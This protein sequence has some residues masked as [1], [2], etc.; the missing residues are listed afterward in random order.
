LRQ[1]LCVAERKFDGLFPE[2]PIL[3]MIHLPALPAAPRNTMTLDELVAFALEELE[4]LEGAGIDGVIV[5]NVGDTPFFREGVP[6][7]TVAAMG[8]IVRE[9]ARAATVPV[10]VN[11]LRNAWEEAVSVA[12]VA[13]AQ[14][15]R[16]NVVIGAYVT[17][18]GIIQGEA[19][20]M[21]RLRKSLDRDV[22][23]LGDVHVKHAAPL[24]DVPLVDA[25]RDLAERGGVD[26]VIV[27][28]RRSPDPPTAEMVA[29]VVDAIELP[30]LI[31]SGLGKA[32]ACEFYELSGGILLGEID[33]KV[34]RVWGGASDQSAYARTIAACRTRSA[35]AASGG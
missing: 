14:F 11:M 29:S 8:V 27:S 7:V 2:R 23:V 15:I 12:Y 6:P 1:D 28:G 10:G 35:R 13:G 9:V 4:R 26:A 18:Q 30:V 32:N 3:G 34:G 16:C 31:G 19:A 20:R 5:E 22:L 25:A 21:A 33:F 24:F 17:D